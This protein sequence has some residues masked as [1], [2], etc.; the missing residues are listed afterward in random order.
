MN[1]QFSQTRV[2]GRTVLAVAGAT[3]LT[4][5]IGAPVQG[6][7]ELIVASRGNGMIL[8]FDAYTGA[9]LG[10]FTDGPTTGV[11]DPGGIYFPADGSLYISSS[12]GTTVAE[13]D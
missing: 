8:R 10:V 6:G 12:S 3:A 2:R 4:L 13:A 1:H 11:P 7:D 9:Y 5:V